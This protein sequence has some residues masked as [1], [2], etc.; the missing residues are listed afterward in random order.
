MI[1]CCKIATG[2]GKTKVMSLVVAWSYFNALREPGSDL[3]RN[4]VII[5]PNLTVYERLKDDFENIKI[6]NSDPLIPEEW[7]GDFQMKTIL[8]D[9]PGGETSSGAIYLTNIHRLYKTKDNNNDISD[10]I[11]GPEVKRNKALDTSTAL[12]ERISMHKGIMVI[13]DEAHHLH[14]PELA[15]NKAIDSLHLMSVNKG[16]GG[17]CLQVDFTATPKHNNGDFFRHII[18][19]FPLGEAVDAGIVKVPVLGESDRL[20]IYGDKNTPAH[21][22]YRNHLQVGYQRYEESYKEWEKVRNHLFVMTEDL[23]QPMKCLVS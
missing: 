16:N 2:G 10:S 3:V 8:Q 7:I 4:F 19:D 22:K 11:W 1:G 9:E 12:R 20:N 17:V 23:H 15:W 13:N 18:C 21:E 14:D 6:F 5:A